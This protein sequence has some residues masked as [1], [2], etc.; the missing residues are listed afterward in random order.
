MNCGARMDGH[1]WD[2]RMEKR[3]DIN[4]LSRMEVYQLVELALT[5]GMRSW[6]RWSV[7]AISREFARLACRKRKLNQMKIYAL[8]LFDRRCECI[9]HQ[10][11]NTSSS[12][13]TTGLAAETT[14]GTKQQPWEEDAKLVY[15]MLF[16]LNNLIAKLGT[17]PRDQLL[18]FKTSHYRLLY[19]ATPSGLKFVLFTEPT[20]DLSAR[21]HLLHIYSQIYVEYAVKNPLYRQ[22]T[23]LMDCEV[24]KAKL[25][26]Y[27]KSC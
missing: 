24:F 5:K 18:S 9:F 22:L 2:S 13:T 15:G 19:Y 17:R 7:S 4:C 11:W 21:S 6:R 1:P 12:S 16:S 8:Y 27:I 3:V 23:S 20:A 26:E 10:Q 25:D 14:E